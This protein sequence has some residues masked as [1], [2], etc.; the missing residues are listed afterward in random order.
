M[1]PV[2]RPTLTMFSVRSIHDP[3]KLVREWLS[4]FVSSTGTDRVE[5]PLLDATPDAHAY[6]ECFLLEKP[7]FTGKTE[8][9]PDIEQFVLVQHPSSHPR[10]GSKQNKHQHVRCRA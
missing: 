6:H 5:F 1:Q 3:P 2:T 9:E 10:V 8:L 4:N 7:F